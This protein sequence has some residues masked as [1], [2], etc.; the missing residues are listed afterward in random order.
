MPIQP[1]IL[2]LYHG[3]KALALVR[4]TARKADFLLSSLGRNRLL[5][6]CITPLL[7]CSQRV[8]ALRDSVP[9]GSGPHQQPLC[10]S[11]KQWA[12][13]TFLPRCIQLHWQ[14]P[15]GDHASQRRGAAVRKVTFKA[16]PVTPHISVCW[17]HD[18]AQAIL[19]AD[20]PAAFPTVLHSRP[21]A[22]VLE[23]Q[24][25]YH[26]LITLMFQDALGA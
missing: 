17:H 20:M 5:E 24:L 21:L 11:A 23:Q 22:L 19:Q 25:C 9:G 1:C 4:L 2:L 15:G 7:C 18:W 12:G 8:A 10:Q 26:R 16:L 3:V 13:S 6:L 14:P